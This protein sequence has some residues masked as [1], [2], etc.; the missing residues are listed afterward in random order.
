MRKLIYLGFLL[1]S[2]G[3]KVPVFSQN[4]VPFSLEMEEITYKD[5]PGLHS[6]AFGE[7]CWSSLES[8]QVIEQF[9]GKLPRGVYG[10]SL[11][12][13]QQRGMSKIIKI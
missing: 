2:I 10:L 13:E 9:L 3:L 7:W 8:L 4:K 5:W 6:F 12:N 1:V 11:Y